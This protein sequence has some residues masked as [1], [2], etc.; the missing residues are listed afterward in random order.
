MARHDRYPKR[1]RKFEIPSQEQE[2]SEDFIREQIRIA[3]ERTPSR[4]HTGEPCGKP[5]TVNDAFASEVYK[6]MMDH[7]NPN[8]V[9]GHMFLG[10]YELERESMVMTAQLLGLQGEEVRK[11]TGFF[12][13][14]G[15][16]STNQAIWTFRNKFYSQK[17]IDVRKEGFLGMARAGVTPKILAPIDSHFSMEKGT[18][19]FGLGT[20]SVAFYGLDQ[21]YSTDLDDLAKRLEQE[22]RQGNELMIN[23]VVVGDTVK[24]KLHDVKAITEVVSELSEKYDKPVPPTVIDAAGQYLFLSLMKDSDKY[25]GDIPSWNFEVP[26]VSAVIC[27]AHKNQIPY[28]TG[29]VIFRDARDTLFTNFATDYLSTDMLDGVSSLSEDEIVL[30]QV[31]ATIPT[32]RGGYG[33]AATWAYYMKYGME[34]MREKKEHI[35]EVT[36]GFRDSVEASTDY[37]LVYEPQTAN[38]VFRLKPE[39]FDPELNQVVY[40]NINNSEE[41]GFYIGH[42]CGGLARSLEERKMQGSQNYVLYANIMDHNSTDSMNTLMQVLNVEAERLKR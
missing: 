27:D 6:Y 20:D 32:S 22:Y 16:E 18:D 19:I 25:G 35:W 34:G 30:A 38:V 1:T 40:R 28:G 10:S 7:C 42:D 39:I 41:H 23:W 17:G 21:D 11:S 5:G 33:P 3:A 36:K 31:L 8:N 24:G 13:S 37:E 15:T 29:M 26:E 9:D 12:L 14:G 2:F 4:Y